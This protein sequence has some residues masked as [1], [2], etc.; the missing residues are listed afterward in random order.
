M[1]KTFFNAIIVSSLLL[2]AGGGLFL[3]KGLQNETVKEAKADDV[4]EVTLNFNS[5][6]SDTGTPNQINVK[7]NETVIPLNTTLTQVS[8]DGCWINGV[9]TYN[10]GMLQIEKVHAYNHFIYVDRINW[11]KYHD[12]IKEGD[13]LLIQG[14]WTAV[15]G[16]TTY[17][18][19]VIPV[20]FQWNGSAWVKLT[21]YQASVTINISGTNKGDMRLN[22]GSENPIPYSA[23]WTEFSNSM[24]QQTF[25]VNGSYVAKDTKLFKLTKYQY[26]VAMNDVQPVEA[27]DIVVINGT[28]AYP[29][30]I[31]HVSRRISIGTI[32]AGWTGSEWLEGAPF[33]SQYFLNSALCDYGNN[34][35]STSLWA[36]LAAR[37]SYL[38]NDCTDYFKNAE[39]TISG[40][41]V[42]PAHGASQEMA[43]FAAR[44]DYIITKYGSEAY[45][46]F[47]NRFNG[48]VVPPASNTFELTMGSNFN[49]TYLI[50][51]CIAIVSASSVALIFIIRRH[52]R[53]TK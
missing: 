53:V 37:F 49:Y 22:V 19:T 3:G 51:A 13:T 27:G 40:D 10:D 4:V 38:G 15:S 11:A 5:L 42:T 41:V 52:R 26:A 44:Y 45:N 18:I 32:T 31:N 12:Y 34:A 43:E 35:P 46:D 14:K 20:Y 9:P 33:F 24:D 17:D 23:S 50:I 39:Y 2:L 16:E 28:F 7:F 30:D 1:K 36:D 47:A 48:Q 25:K 21:E 29:Y 8:E 6:R